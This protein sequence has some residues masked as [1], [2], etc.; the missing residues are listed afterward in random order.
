[1]NHLD[2]F[3]GI[4]GFALAARWAGIETIWFCEKDKFCQKV[5][6]K[7]WPNVLIHDDIKTF[8]YNE[9]VDLLTAGFPC[10]PFSVAGKRK[11]K[12]DDRYLW[13]ETM[14]IIRECKPNWLILENV[15]SIIPMLDPILE[16]L[17][18]EGY[19]WRAFLIPAS[20]VGAPHKRERLWIIANRDRIRCGS[21]GDTRKERPVQIDWEQYVKTLQ[22]EWSQFQP[23]SWK[24]FDIKNFLGFITDTDEISAGERTK[25]KDAESIRS[26]WPFI[27]AEN[28]QHK[29]EFGWFEYFTPFPGVD[30]GLPSRLDRN[31][32][33]GNAIVPQIPYLFMIM[34]KEIERLK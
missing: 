20:S 23:Q 21:G 26:E 16:D 22:S 31:K 12:D 13:P 29:S 32:S 3:S 28:R 25:N 8:N 30:D 10:Q 18:R 19:N 15:P 4:G 5:L 33:L 34:I 17:E 24:T 6:R 1:M 11:G 7:H 2:L 14:R 27:A 9:K